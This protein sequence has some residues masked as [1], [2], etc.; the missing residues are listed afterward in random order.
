MIEPYSTNPITLPAPNGNTSY[1]L[2]VP[3]QT[4][5]ESLYF[6]NGIKR[7]YNDYYQI[8]GNVLYI[9]SAFPPEIGDTHEL[10]AN[11]A[12]DNFMELGETNYNNVNAAI[13]NTITNNSNITGITVILDNTSSNSVIEN[14]IMRL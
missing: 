2:P 10:Y 11:A 1:Y 6:V 9:L 14:A 5:N 4:T 12:L 7:I 13:I 8:S 3:P